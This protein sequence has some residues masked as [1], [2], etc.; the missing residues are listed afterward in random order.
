MPFKGRFSAIHDGKTQIQHNSRICKHN[1]LILLPSFLLTFNKSPCFLSTWEKDIKYVSKWQQSIQL[2]NL[3]TKSEWCRASL[4]PCQVMVYGRNV[5]LFLELEPIFLTSWVFYTQSKITT[6]S[7]RVPC[8]INPFGKWER[9]KIKEK[10]GKN[11]NM[12][13]II[14][15]SKY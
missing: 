7:E 11:Q 12:K 3:R 8:W 1:I 14:D 10:N 6:N 5:L 9:W 13:R 15:Q 4:E 2:L